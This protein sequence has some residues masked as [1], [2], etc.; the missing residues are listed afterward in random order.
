MPTTVTAKITFDDKGAQ[1]ASTGDGFLLRDRGGNEV[2]ISLNAL[3]RC[4][5]IAEYEK[6]LPALSG[7]FWQSVDQLKN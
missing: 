3:V 4:L 5:A 7:E 1:I 6:T 2:T